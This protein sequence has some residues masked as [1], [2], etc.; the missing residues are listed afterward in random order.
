MPVQKDAVVASNVIPLLQLE[1]ES[2]SVR[3]ARIRRARLDT[4]LKR[5]KEGLISDNSGHAAAE[6]RHEERQFPGPLSRKTEHGE[7]TNRKG[8]RLAPKRRYHAWRRAAAGAR[9]GAVVRRE[10]YHVALEMEQQMITGLDMRGNEKKRRRPRRREAHR[11]RLPPW[12]A[13][14]RRASRPDPKDLC[15]SRPRGHLAVGGR[16]PGEH[17]SPDLGEDAAGLHGGGD[18]HQSSDATTG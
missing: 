15:G 18:T 7:A 16:S 13:S 2:G 5:P 17:S 9:S 14:A 4:L 12:I 8:H 10:K 1:G 11:G 6:W 3:Y